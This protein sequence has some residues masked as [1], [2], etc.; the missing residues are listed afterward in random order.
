M[1]RIRA[2]LAALCAT[3]VVAS[4]TARPAVAQA[5]AGTD[6]IT[7]VITGDEGPIQDA[8]VEAYSLETQVTRRARTDA[9][10]RFTILFPD[11][12]GQY[13]MTARAIGMAPRIEVIQRHADEDRL[14]WNA[15]L[16]G[17]TVTLEEITVRGGLQQVR[18]PEGPTPG[19]TERVINQEQMARLPVDATDLALLAALTPGVL[20]I[21]STDSTATAFSVAGLG[22]D[23]NAMTLDGL[24]FGSS[25]IPQEG[26]R[27]T[28]VVTSTYDVSRGQFS[29]GLISSTTR[30]GSNVV[31]GS[32][33]YQL[34]DDDLAVT[35]DDS[36][37][38]SGFTQHVI[39]GGLGGPLRRD[40]L[41]LFGS[42]QARLRS[43]PQQTLLS[44]GS[45]DY[46]RLGVHPDSV[47]RFFDIVDAL[48][49]PH[50]SVPGSDTRSSDNLSALVRLD[51]VLSNSH[52]V[53]LRGDWQG[54]SQD[55]TRLGSL[56]LPQT[57]GVLETGG[58]GVMATLTS[59][60]GATLL[61][62]FR[63]YWQGSRRDGDPFTA[64]PAGRVQVASVLDDGTRSV[65]TLVF[66]GNSGL[67]TRNRSGTVEVS[68]EASWIPGTGAHRIRIGAWARGEDTRDI[69]GINSLGTFTYLSL[70]DLENGA[71]A[72]F[73]RT[74][75]VPE[76]VSRNYRYGLYVGDVWMV[77]RPFQLTYGL[78]L[79]GSA[80]GASPEYN[81][82]VEAAF[83]RR[84]DRLPE[85]WHLSPRA[86]FSWQLG[87]GPS[88]ANRFPGPPRLVVRGGIGEFRNQP[89]VGLAAQARAN[90]G[91]SQAAG[92]ISCFGSDVPAPQWGEYW[93]NASAI[94]E[95]CSGGG[96]GTGAL[97]P[98]TVTLI[99]DNFEA[100]RAWRASLG[101][102]RRL[103]QLIR[104][105]VDGSFS[106]GVAQT[107]YWDLNLVGAP[108]FN[109]GAEDG[110]PV[111]V[112]PGS[113]TP[114]TGTPR[115]AA[116]RVDSAFGSVLDARSVLRSASEQVTV[117]L[118]GLMG[119]G[120]MVN[121]SY[122]M[123]FSRDQS[124]GMRGTTAGDP[125]LVEWSRSD[126][127]R[128][129][130]FL[131]TLTY[132]L[133]Q[134]V[135][136]TSIGRLTSGTPYTPMVGGDVNGDGSRNDRAFIFAPGGSSAES[137]GMERL[138]ASASEGVRECLRG[139][140]GSI[141]RR[142]S[143]TG[144]WQ[145]SLDFQLNVRPT[146]WGLNRRVTFSVVTQNFLRGLDELLHGMDDLRG[147]GLSTRPDNTLLYVTGFD[148]VANRYSYQ[149]NERFGSTAGTA[150]AFR[151]P[152][153]IGFQMRLSIGPDRMR[154]ALDAM[155]A[156]G[157]GAMVMAG[158]GGPGA[159]Q[160]GFR[161]P[162]TSPG[163][164]FNR[165]L[166]ALPNPP[167]V[168]LEMRDSLR[169]S[170]SQVSLLEPERDSL[171]IRLDTRLDSLRQALQTGGSTPDFQ[172][173]MPLMRPAFEG[174]RNAIAQSLVTL[175]AVLTPE[176]WGML[177]D[178]VRNFQLGPQPGQGGP[179]F[180][181]QRP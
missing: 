159:G 178:N 6:I 148:P 79:E 169:L 151:P 83:G 126:F 116:S 20:S 92:E 31:Q 45:A 72:S 174:A 50:R 141:A 88:G 18:M 15:R 63:G 125:N 153:Q 117:S 51:W 27:Q 145:Y 24:L 52:T 135:E 93:L 71:A 102:E 54:T 111:F 146:F 149:V 23:A 87:G 155:R 176:Q 42:M 121:G 3:L 95:E 73:R 157:G 12:G 66:G 110:R 16:T 48:G 138:L 43:D 109:L 22:P 91:L 115:F 78:R 7:G 90:T 36:P 94:P 137:Q 1:S 17:G 41:F 14:V 76:R 84:T 77:T 57:G 58:G 165:I 80:F 144:P 180:Q 160:M 108:A 9:R 29:G 67:P 119:R 156:R 69:L 158:P 167:G 161:G 105:T 34:R 86:G 173:I 19:S 25:S 37:F 85:E 56:A 152:F 107:G 33:N 143:C 177:P 100:S 142:N 104:L 38:A 101:V 127:G 128:R 134:S 139:Q 133:S 49:V 99:A 179:R 65:S 30:S 64:L 2:A 74:V 75:N 147:W 4:L 21:S 168:A 103:S 120:I 32:S 82:A 60:F 8:T 140:A 162:A 89:P 98:R 171:R 70:A 129:H 46:S 112:A 44:A 97:A 68:N 172:R 150:T 55:P 5:G 28:R 39:S 59:R 181:M 132:P 170:P 47:A 81:P 131:A 62:E 11:G 130:N 175:R 26:L 123:Q 40:R 163:E 53:T 136:V 35:E 10:G 118:G 96:A 122:T 61:N 166:A 113:I 124:T 114:S 13:R 154:Q 106:R 164:A